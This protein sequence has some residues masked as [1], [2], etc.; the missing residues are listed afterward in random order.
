MYSNCMRYS[1]KTS[2]DIIKEIVCYLE[3][4]SS[5]F[6]SINSFFFPKCKQKQQAFWNS[7][8][9][10]TELQTLPHHLYTLSCAA[11]ITS[12]SENDGSSLE[13]SK[14]GNV[15]ITG[16]HALAPPTMRTETCYP[17]AE[18][19]VPN[20][21]T[22]VTGAIR[23]AATAATGSVASGFNAEGP[24]HYPTQNSSSLMMPRPNSVAGTV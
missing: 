8:F 16:H 17:V 14:E 23:H 15:R 24:V 5:I 21:Y 9:F 20:S 1:S 3:N 12:S 13:W 2:S 6:S 19:E 22:E 4:Y 11:T 7:F 18:E 10:S